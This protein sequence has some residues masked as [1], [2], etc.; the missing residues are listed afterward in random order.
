MYNYI[1][2]FFSYFFKLD[3]CKRNK[4][5]IILLIILYIFL[6][7]LLFSLYQTVILQKKERYINIYNRHILYNYIYLYIFL[8]TKLFTAWSCVRVYVLVGD[9]YH[10]LIYAYLNSILVL[11]LRSSYSIFH[12]DCGKVKRIKY[13]L[14]LRHGTYEMTLDWF[15]KKD[16]R[17]ER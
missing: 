12:E 17:G 3:F 8:Y 15:S 10:L 14:R 6:L 4:A 11:Y 2:T 7:L 9:Q 13:E 16:W 5:K 1:R